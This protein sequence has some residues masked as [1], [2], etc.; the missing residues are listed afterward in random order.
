MIEVTIKKGVCLDPS[1]VLHVKFLLFLERSV[2]FHHTKTY[3]R[4]TKSTPFGLHGSPIKEQT[5]VPMTSVS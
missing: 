1:S 3:K 2:D 5:E 4:V